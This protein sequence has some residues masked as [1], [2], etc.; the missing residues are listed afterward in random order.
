M[1]RI[2]IGLL[3]NAAACLSAAAQTAEFKC[4][5]PGTTTEQADGGR[6]VWQGQEGNYC[7]RHVK[8]RTGDEYPDRWYAPTLTQRSDRSLAFA[9]QVKPWTLWPLSIGKKL[10]ARF[11]GVGSNVGFGS[12]S[13]IQTVTVD[14]Y[15]KVTTKLGTFDVFV[16][17]RNEEAISHRYK[18]TQRQ[19]YAPALG[20]PVKTTFTDSQGR[21]DVYETVKVTP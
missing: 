4:P 13:W 19:W 9:E 5:K 16:V 1:R 6:V 11:D 15:E 17:T 3:L 10:T 7:T 21:N 12:G 8:T 20:L 2:A 14:A 18:S